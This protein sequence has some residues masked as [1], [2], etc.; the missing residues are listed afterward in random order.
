MSQNKKNSYSFLK[1]FL[2]WMI[3]TAVFYILPM[4][5]EKSGLGVQEEV[6]NPT[7]NEFVQMV[8]NG[9]VQSIY[10]MDGLE[11]LP[12]VLKD[13]TEV[14][15]TNPEYDDFK[16]EILSKDV[17][18]ISFTEHPEYKSAMRANAVLSALSSFIQI[19]LILFFM[20]FSIRLISSI[21]R[22]EKG[23][24]ASPLGMK[25]PTKSSEDM[26]KLQE[27]KT[28]RDVAGLR[29]S[30]EDLKTIIDFLRNADKYEEAGAKLPKGCLFY[31]P[32]GTGKTLLAKAIAGEA[33]VN[34]LFANASDFVEMY[35]GL[36]ASR[37][38]QLFE[39]ARKKAP[40]IVFID[41]IDAL[42]SKRGA[43]DSH[44]EDKK[45]L[46]AFLTEMDGFMETNG[47]VVIGATNR[48]EDLDEALL[49]PGRLSKKFCIPLPETAEERL[50]IINL[51]N[52]NKKFDDTV[53]FETLSKELI[54]F[55]PAD[56]ENLLNEAAI[57][58]VSKNNGVITKEIL[59]KVVMN[60]IVDGHVKDSVSGR[61]RE[62]LETVAWHE[63]GHALVGRLKGKEITKVT[64]LST[65]SGAGGVTF[66]V[67]KKEHLLSKED[68]SNEV[69]ELYAGRVGELALFG[70]EDKVTTG[71]SNDFEKA[72]SL[73]DK[74]VERFGMTS[75]LG[76][77]IVR[78][79][80]SDVENEKLL[81]MKV[82][83]SKKLME[84]TKEL[85]KKHFD[86]LEEIAEL[87]LKKETIYS[88][89]LDEIFAK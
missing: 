42:G 28:F 18:V 61:S 55:S 10:Y 57:L 5:S 73:I 71:A 49:R 38:R 15:V 23:G 37:V 83:L 8:E 75:E 47:V 50:E 2:C 80:F 16:K 7:Y 33:D 13:G 69:M 51:Y 43:K 48:I 88:S 60:I 24:F 59:N 21:I 58:S 19:L 4:L 89:D 54:G 39:E 70:T 44:S 76:P 78:S 81:Q 9:E 30:K 45:T 85:V 14:K 17:E 36:G 29:E 25:S 40:C 79:K 77:Y 11:E 84:D 53:D 82:D 1:I 68:L 22:G 74:I 67:P 52:K 26:K 65:T 87:L 41:E 64:I 35:V 63:A 66:P 56:I 12:V 46:E 32:P 6:K 34:F 3:I 86:K 62:E 27:P 31:G 72:S 20:M